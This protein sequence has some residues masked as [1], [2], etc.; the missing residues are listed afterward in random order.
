MEVK[1]PNIW[2]NEY[3]DSN[4]HTNLTV[5]LLSIVDSHKKKQRSKENVREKSVVDVI[6]KLARKKQTSM[7]SLFCKICHMFVDHNTSNCFQNPVK[8]N[9][10]A[11]GW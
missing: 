9:T 10:V 11:W 6:K 3:S 4:L 5:T 8:T 1:F 2:L 7:K